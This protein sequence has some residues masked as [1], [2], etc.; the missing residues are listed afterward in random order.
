[1]DV[2][3]TVDPRQAALV[4]LAQSRERLGQA[5]TPSAGASTGATGWRQ[6]RRLGRRLLLGSGWGQ[7]GRMAG[8][9]AG[10]R[11]LPWVQRN[12][13]L[14]VGAGLVVGAGLF[15]AR[16]WLMAAAKLQAL[17][18][19]QTGQ[20]LLLQQTL[21]PTWLQQLLAALPATPADRGDQRP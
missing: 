10:E 13:G 5:L 15:L 8:Q 17:R 20:A 2:H 7:A 14:A 1:M 16:G 19:W 4:R 21:D 12:P 3:H 6:L 11:L 9:V 18:W